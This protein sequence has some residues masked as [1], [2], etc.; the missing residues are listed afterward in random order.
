MTQTTLA[1]H[2]AQMPTVEFTDFGWFT[3]LD[4]VCAD[5]KGGTTRITMYLP[6]GTTTW[7][8]IQALTAVNGRVASNHSPTMCG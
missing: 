7:Q 1:I 6:K 3:S 4:V 2:D 8:V 5:T